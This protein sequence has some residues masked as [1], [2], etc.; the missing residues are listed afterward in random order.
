MFLHELM[1][2]FNNITINFYENMLSN[3]VYLQSFNQIIY[4]DIKIDNIIN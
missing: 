1:K 2:F 3:A 4:T